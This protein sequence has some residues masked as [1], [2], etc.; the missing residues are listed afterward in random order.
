[1]N[2]LVYGLLLWGWSHCPHTFSDPR[3]SAAILP[4]PF[5]LHP[6]CSLGRRGL[7]FQG[8]AIPTLE[9]GLSTGGRPVKPLK[10]RHK[11]TSSG[12]YALLEVHPN[13]LSGKSFQGGSLEC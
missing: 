3:L 12:A 8:E 1:M 13:I 10:S 11:Q 7:L 4:V 6:F 5:D 9:E 2:F